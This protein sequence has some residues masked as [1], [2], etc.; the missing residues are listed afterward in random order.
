MA[1]RGSLEG[2][3]TAAEANGQTLVGFGVSRVL[4]FMKDACTAMVFLG[5]QRPRIV[6][7]D[8][9]CRN[10]LIDD[11][12]RAKVAD[13][14]LARRAAL[15][16]EDQPLSPQLGY[17]YQAITSRALPARWMAPEALLS[18]AVTVPADVWSFGVTMWEA[19]SMGAVPFADEKDWTEAVVSGRTNYTLV[20][21]A[22]CPPRAADLIRA[23]CTVDPACRIEFAALE[24]QLHRVM[25]TSQSTPRAADNPAY[26]KPAAEQRFF[27]PGFAPPPAQQAAAP[28]YQ[29]FANASP[30]VRLTAQPAPYQMAAPGPGVA[31]APTTGGEESRL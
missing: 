9:A 26:E 29:T 21:P 20:T 10:I 14:G 15:K 25:H 31:A 30:P 1:G 12:D 16:D 2:L 4:H 17:A 5:A 3:L 19:F 24:T 23:C 18:G 8:L 27:G 28:R 13:F 22:G 6:H 11:D 7:R